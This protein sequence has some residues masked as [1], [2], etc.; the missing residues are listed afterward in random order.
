[1]GAVLSIDLYQ[2]TSSPLSESEW[3]RLQE[4]VAKLQESITTYEFYTNAIQKIPRKENPAL[5]LGIIMTGD[6]QISDLNQQYRGKEGPTDVITFP[7]EFAEENENE[8]PS[9]E[10]EEIEAEIYI[11]QER[12]GRQALERSHSLFHEIIILVVH[13]IVHA[14]GLDHERSLE[15]ARLMKSFE[16]RLLHSIGLHETKPLT[17]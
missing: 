2:E 6:S 8:F 11:S 14:F 17:Q 15:E 5:H 16:E 9:H 12:A 3:Q 10:L 1:M 13:G 7:F 4:I